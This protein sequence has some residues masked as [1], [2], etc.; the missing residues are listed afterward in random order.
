MSRGGDWYMVP[1]IMSAVI[2]LAPGGTSSRQ[3]AL[4]RKL[5]FCSGTSLFYCLA[6]PSFTV[7]CNCL[8]Q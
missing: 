8:L 6:S 4:T 3:C 7:S 1:T 5:F 2:E